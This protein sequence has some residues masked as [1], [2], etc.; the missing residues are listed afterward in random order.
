VLPPLKV[1]SGLVIEEPA[2]ACD[3]VDQRQGHAG[4]VGPLIRLQTVRTTGSVSCDLLTR[5][6]P[7]EFDGGT[8]RVPQM[9]CDI[10]A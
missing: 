7:L 10:C 1:A 8:Q 4:V 5:T 9:T 6:W 3:A 2:H